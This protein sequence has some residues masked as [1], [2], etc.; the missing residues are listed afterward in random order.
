MTLRSIPELI[1]DVRQN[2]RCISAEQAQQEISKLNNALLLDV[3]EPQEA[4]EHPVAGASNIPRGVLEMQMLQR[5]NQ[6]DLAIYIHCATGIRASLAA[7]Q[8]QRVGYNN[9]SVITCD[10][11]TIC[12][13]I[14]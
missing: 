13:K 6:P 9:V 7:E 1:A 8:L 10:L 11:E 2:L 14:Q 5:F 12:T 3:R 4:M